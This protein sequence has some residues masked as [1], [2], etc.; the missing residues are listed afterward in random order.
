MDTYLEVT[1]I[2]VSH[3]EPTPPLKNAE[4]GLGVEK[5]NNPMESNL[6]DISDIIRAW[7]LDWTPPE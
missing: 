3:G 5:S 2:V 4:D 7:Q 1:P 6:L